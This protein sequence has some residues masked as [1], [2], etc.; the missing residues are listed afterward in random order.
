MSLT[1]SSTKT[2]SGT[3]GNYSLS[4]TFTAS[5]KSAS[6]EVVPADST[7]NV[8]VFANN[9]SG[10]LKFFAI[11]SQKAGTFQ[12]KD[13][14][15]TVLG[16]QQTLAPN[17]SKVVFGSALTGS[18][19]YNQGDIASVDVAND[20]TSATSDVVVDLLYDATP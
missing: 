18:D 13:S 20:D 7:L 9:S 19:F 2:F 5:A 4:E 17:V 8:D 10:E 1:I 15:G 3:S 16:S 11:K 14:S 12:L 6:S